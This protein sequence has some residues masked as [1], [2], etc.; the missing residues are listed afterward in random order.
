[1]V[2]AQIVA[3]AKQGMSLIQVKIAANKSAPILD[4][5]FSNR[6]QR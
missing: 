5:I 2:Y 4:H 6:P 1:M 3:F